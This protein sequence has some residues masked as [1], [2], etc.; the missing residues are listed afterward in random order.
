MSTIGG[1]AEMK[2][3]RDQNGLESVFQRKEITS[4]IKKLPIKGAAS[5]SELL[6]N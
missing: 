6:Q 3:A 2:K 4:I 5:L 1:G